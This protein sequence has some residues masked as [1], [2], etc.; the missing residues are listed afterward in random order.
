MTRT[1]TICPACGS[2]RVGPTEYGL[3]GADMMLDGLAWRIVLGGCDIRDG[4]PQ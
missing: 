3:P 4:N 1:V 2:D